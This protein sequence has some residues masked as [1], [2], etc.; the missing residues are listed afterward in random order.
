MKKLILLFTFVLLSFEFNAQ[1]ETP[2]NLQFNRVVNY[3]LDFNTGEI[4][5]NANQGHGVVGTITIPDGKVWKIESVSV[6]HRDSSRGNSL[7]GAHG[8]CHLSLGRMKIY[9]PYGPYSDSGRIDIFP[10]WIPSGEYDVYGYDCNNS[11]LSL[12]AIEFNIVN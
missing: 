11:A 8:S 4:T 1:Q 10:M 2:G 7:S 6:S 12:S 9:D 5:G 3:T